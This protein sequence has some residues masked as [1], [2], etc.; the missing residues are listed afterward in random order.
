MKTILTIFFL[1]LACLTFNKT[2]VDSYFKKF[3]LDSDGI[4]MR[5]EY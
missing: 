1:V 5:I 3:D 4:L 2:K